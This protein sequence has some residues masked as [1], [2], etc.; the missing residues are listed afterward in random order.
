MN[1]ITLNNGTK[2]PV[3]GYGTWQLTGGAC[4]ESV[5]NALGMGYRHI[6]TAQIYENEA[7]VGFGIARSGVVREDIFLTTKIWRSNLGAAQ[8]IPSFEESLRKLQTDY[9]DLL[10]IHWPMNEI[11]FAE[12]LEQ[13]VKLQKSGKVLNIGVSNFT[14]SQVREVVKQGYPIITNQAEYHPLLSQT[15]LLNCCHAEGMFLTAYSPLAR[16]AVMDDPTLQ[17]IAAKHNKSPA[18][19]T[20][21]WLVQQPGVVAIPKAASAK[22]AQA[23]LEIFSFEL[24]ESEMQ[25]ISALARNLRVVNPS[26]AP[27]WDSAA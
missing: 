4:R 17:A 8:V 15:A 23:N 5:I 21:R 20:L 22:N 26:F 12:S 6:D 3:L 13:F 27:K 14:V 18:Q 16:G 11:P 9:V 25:S 19:I 7:E 24:S 10:L 1:H 2:V